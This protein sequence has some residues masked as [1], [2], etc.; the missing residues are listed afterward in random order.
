MAINEIA[1]Y[2]S[3]PLGPFLVPSTQ[4]ST[5]QIL[6]GLTI[7]QINRSSSQ[8]IIIFDAVDFLLIR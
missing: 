7:T 5:I 6:T 1:A 3:S 4:R 2:P 8:K